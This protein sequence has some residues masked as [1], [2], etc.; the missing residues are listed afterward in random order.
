MKRTLRQLS[1]VV[2][3]CM[4]AAGGIPVA[5]QQGEGRRAATERERA[6]QAQA[7]GEDS[8]RAGLEQALIAQGAGG[9]GDFVFLATEMSL[10]G[11]LVK[12]APYSAEAVTETTQTLGDGNRIT[13]KTTATVYRDSEGRTRREQTLKAIGPFAKTGEPNQTIFIS[14]PVAGTSYTLDPSS[15]TATKLPPL[16]FNLRGEASKSAMVV[17]GGEAPAQFRVRAQQPQAEGAP[18]KGEKFEIAVEPPPHALDKI[19]LESG[20]S[21]GWL[22]TNNPNARNESLGKQNINGVEAEGSRHT[23]TIPVGE[24]GNERA[25]E[26]I[27][28][29]WYSPELQLIVMTRHSDPRFGETTYLLTNINRNEPSHDLF[30]VPAGYTIK[31]RTPAQGI[32]SGIK[33][34]VLNGKAITLPLPEYPEIARV[35][36][37]TGSVSVNVTIDEEG[38]VI[39]AESVTG[40]P[41]L[42]SAAV[43]AA[44]RARFSPTRL[45]GQPVKVSGVLVY[46][47]SV[48]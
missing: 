47:F 36:K 5:S 19:V 31:D 25:I 34:G 41:L 43:D 46:Q 38:N 29:K 33:G 40:H 17:S 32:G 39:S 6:S 28:E 14:D 7:G 15:Q 9:G 4:F 11:K 27:S 21:L 12:G 3:I 2:L 42:R 10:G 16:R 30:E 8:T 35:A 26:I 18:A 24:I 22:E 45:S 48:Q 37:A 44:R 23:V 13:R 20:V 1:V